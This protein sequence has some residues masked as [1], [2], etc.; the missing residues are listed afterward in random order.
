MSP[1]VGF[2]AIFGTP[3][4]AGLAGTYTV[5]CAV[6]CY[7]S[8]LICVLEACML[9]LPRTKTGWKLLGGLQRFVLK[10]IP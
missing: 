1:T 2:H 5:A 4:N 9:P 3:Q 7:G 8:M 10:D 6:K